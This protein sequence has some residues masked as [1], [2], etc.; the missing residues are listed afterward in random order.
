M[1]LQQATL[2]AGDAG[3]VWVNSFG[4]MAR[5]H[6][7]RTYTIEGET[8]FANSAYR[9]PSGIIW[10]VGL[11]AI[12]HLENGRSSRHAL[13]EQIESAY[14]NSINVAEDHAGVLWVAAEREGLF[15]M[16][17]GVWR[18][19]ETPPE[20]ARLEPTAAFTDSVGRVWFGYAKGRIITVNGSKIQTL[21]SDDESPVGSVRAIQG[22]DR[23][24]WVGGGLG[25][26]ILRWRPLQASGSSGHWNIWKRL[27]N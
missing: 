9:D 4:H 27:R 10:G 16:K 25:F 21:S 22:R 14:S 11:H 23:H 12:Y 8:D 7:G 1:T 13:P 19:F 20:L 6:S 26:G 15:Y 5:V 3:D 17:K 18:R 24:I 2:A